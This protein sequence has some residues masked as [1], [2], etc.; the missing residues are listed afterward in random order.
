MNIITALFTNLH[1]SYGLLDPDIPGEN[2]VLLSQWRTLTQSTK[3]WKLKL[4]KLI[5]FPHIQDYAEDSS[6]FSV[7]VEENGGGYN[8]QTCFGKDEEAIETLS[9]LFNCLKKQC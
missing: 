3:S 7:C 8:I 9:L 5:L 4:L 1:Q 6:L 2:P